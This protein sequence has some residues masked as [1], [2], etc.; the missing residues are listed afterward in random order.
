VKV[1]A[2]ALQAQQAGQPAALVTI[3]G[4]SGSAPR[5]GG[6]RMLVYPDGAIKGTVGGGE[7][8]HRVIKIALRSIETGRPER[9]A[10]HLTRDLGMCC[11]GAMEAYIEPLEATMDL[12]IYGS[13]HV[14]AATA[15]LVDG[16]GFRVTILDE[17]EELIEDARFGEAIHTISTH[18]LGRLD[19]LPWGM[20]AFHLVV[21][22]SHQLDQDLVQAILPRPIG[23]L[24]MIGSRAKVAKFLIRYRAAGI[25][26]TLFAKLSAPVGLDIGA[27]TPEEIAVSIVAELVRLR[28]DPQTTCAPLADSPIDARGGD[29][30]AHP[31]RAIES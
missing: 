30:A 12:V 15:R 6:A 10:A 11:G 7:F 22:H 27:E 9:F 29:G 24:G 3:V 16:L 20:N 4:I 28:R 31:P 5:K 2:A 1:L 23:W 14:G 8:E 17:R 25:D 19:Q 26:E 13:G 18:P 21:T